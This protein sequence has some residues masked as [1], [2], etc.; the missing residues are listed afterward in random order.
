MW[1][2]LLI[3]KQF[4]VATDIKPKGIHVSVSLLYVIKEINFN[5]LAIEILTSQLG[6]CF[7]L[8]HVLD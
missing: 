1:L 4:Q 5:S 8:Y 3:F 2:F 7:Q 6:K